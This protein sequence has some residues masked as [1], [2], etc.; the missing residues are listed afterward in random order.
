[1]VCSN[2]GLHDVMAKIR[3]FYRSMS[4]PSDFELAA[5]CLLS[6]DQVVKRKP[7]KCHNKDHAYVADVKDAT[8]STLV[9]RKPSIGKNGSH[10]RWCTPE[11]FHELSKEKKDE[12][13]EFR[14]V[15]RENET[16]YKKLKSSREIETRSLVSDLVAKN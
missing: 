10:L 2:A 8:S 15:N 13:V 11:D 3:N 4:N 14:R 9:F 16:P 1:M 6:C 7:I 5:T 12:L